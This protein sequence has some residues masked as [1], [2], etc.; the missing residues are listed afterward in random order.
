MLWHVGVTHSCLPMRSRLLEKGLPINDNYVHCEQLAETYIHT[1]FCVCS[2]AMHCWKLIGLDS[3]VRNLLCVAN[4][5]TSHLF[6]FF[7]SISVQQQEMAS[8]ILWSLWKSRNTKL[9]EGT[10][11]P[12]E[13]I[14]LRAKNSLQEWMHMQKAWQPS[15]CTHHQ[16]LWEKLRLSWWNVMRTVHSLITTPLQVLVSALE[17]FGFSKYPYFN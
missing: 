1:F 10:N 13:S 9:C 12:S 17:K 14:L 5:F 6:D 3:T 8:M 2:K 7:N 16:T 4:D 15:Q 11:T